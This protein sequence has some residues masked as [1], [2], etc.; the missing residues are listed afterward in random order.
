MKIR[1][2]SVPELM[3]E[4]AEFNDNGYLIVYMGGKIMGRIER[5]EM[6]LMG[7]VV[8]A[9]DWHE[10]L[11]AE[12]IQDTPEPRT[13]SRKPGSGFVD[14]DDYPEPPLPKVRLRY[15][16]NPDRDICIAGEGSPMLDHYIERAKRYTEIQPI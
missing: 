9:D 12:V 2:K 8:N 15:F 11:V 4:G 13:K 7:T 6:H 10:F 16:Q 14:F 1:L 5:D 3:A